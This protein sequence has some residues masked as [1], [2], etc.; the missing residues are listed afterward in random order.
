[1]ANWMNIDD[2]TVYLKVA[3]PTIYKLLKEKKIPG[4]KLGSGWR[5]DQNEVDEWIKDKR[6]VKNGRWTK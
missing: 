4:H 5:F 2:L 3:K 1:M 6:S